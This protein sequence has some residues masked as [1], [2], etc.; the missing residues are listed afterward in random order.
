MSHDSESLANNEAVEAAAREKKYAM[1]V[2]N[3]AGNEFTMIV[4]M[5]RTGGETMVTIHK[6]EEGE[7]IDASNMDF[8]RRM[9]VGRSRNLDKVAA[10][11]EALAQARSLMERDGYT[12]IK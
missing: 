4:Q 10:R 1:R 11:N 8:T 6:L 12:E 9:C 5:D 7:T 3:A 2:R